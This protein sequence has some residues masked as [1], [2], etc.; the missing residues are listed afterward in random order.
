MTGWRKTRFW[1]GGRKRHS[2]SLDEL[3]AVKVATIEWE[4]SLEYTVL[5]WWGPRVQGNSEDVRPIGRREARIL[6]VV[7]RVNTIDIG[8][9]DEVGGWTHCSVLVG[10]TVFL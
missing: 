9:R 7:R 5:A 1:W 2:R 4:I 3:R 6:Q 8:E 10:A